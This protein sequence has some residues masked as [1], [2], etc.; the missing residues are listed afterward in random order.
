MKLMMNE[1]WEARE[2]RNACQIF[3]VNL[4]GGDH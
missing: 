3:A 4:K 1:T 2:K